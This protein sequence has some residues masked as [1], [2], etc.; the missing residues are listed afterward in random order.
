MGKFIDG[1]KLAEKIKDNIVK[2]IIRLGSQSKLTQAQN[3]I[4]MPRP[5]L[6]IIMVGQRPDSALYAELKIKE[7]KKVG[8][9]THLYKCDAQINEREIFSLIECLN[10]DNSID[11]ILVQLP[12]PTGFDTDGIIR[13]INPTKDVDC[14]HPDNLKIL[15]KTC[16]HK[17]VIPPVFMAVLEIFKSINYNL[18]GQKICLVVNSD[19][20]GRGLAKILTCKGAYID[21]IKPHSKNL[22]DQTKVADVL[23][24]AVG[25]KHFIKKNMVKNGVVVIDIGITREGKKVYGDVDPTVRDKASYLTPVPGGIGPLTIAMLFKNTLALYKKRRGL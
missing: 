17:A 8:I 15:F 3:I 6:A 12:L 22:D 19:I 23:I 20:F 18:T 4:R 5:N 21:L 10:Q 7:A 2:E 16:R 9:D 11:A 13:A 25:Q 14:F 1:R 24:T